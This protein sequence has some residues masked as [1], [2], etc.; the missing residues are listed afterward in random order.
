MT[1]EDSSTEEAGALWP[2]AKCVAA[3]IKAVNSPALVIVDATL[4]Y[5]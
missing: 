5:H 1:E 3:A 4:P 2:D